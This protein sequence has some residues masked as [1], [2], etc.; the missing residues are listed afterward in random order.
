MHAK[1]MR[2]ASGSRMQR[3]CVVV[4]TQVAVVSYIATGNRDT[5]MDAAYDQYGACGI[6]LRPL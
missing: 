3:Y 6:T 4:K 2:P 1:R 5:L